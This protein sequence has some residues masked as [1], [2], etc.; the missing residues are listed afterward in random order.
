M[1]S[2]ENAQPDIAPR[3]PGPIATP[4]NFVSLEVGG[5]VGLLFSHIRQGTIPLAQGQAVATGAPLGQVGHSGSNS[6]PHLHLEAQDIANGFSS[7]PLAI[8]NAEVR[9]NPVSNDP[10][11]RHVGAW[12]IREGMFVANGAERVPALDAAPFALLG[13]VLVLGAGVAL[14]ARRRTARPTA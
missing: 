1:F 4:P 11:L 12:G 3:S 7:L 14:R 13:L 2:L 5:D 6:W 9:L 10:W 8:R